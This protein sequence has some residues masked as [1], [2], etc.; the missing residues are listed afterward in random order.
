MHIRIRKTCMKS[1]KD[2]WGHK[3]EW[4]RVA[5]APAVVW[6]LGVVAMGLV[7]LVA[8]KPFYV[9]EVIGGKDIAV[10]QESFAIGFA[11][12]LYFIAGFVAY[13]T[14]GIN[15]LRYAVL[16]EGGTQWWTLHFD[17]R[18]VRYIIYTILIGALA[19]LAIL[20]AGSIVLGAHLLMDSMA[21]TLILAVL[22]GLCVLYPL[23][24]TGLTLAL[25]VFD[26]DAPIRTSWRLLKGNVL[27]FIGVMLLIGI[28]WFVI[29]LVGIIILALLGVLFSLI[30]LAPLA[31]IL[32]AP[33]G[34]VLW[35]LYWA[36]MIK[37]VGLVYKTLTEGNLA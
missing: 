2:V 3:L 29:F 20:V 17:R 28:A 30:D 10:I 15:G 7:Y 4:V 5:F 37:A 12:L 24:R 35:F 13:I 32:A 27:R 36:V 22:L 34:V 8:G 23:T 9:H 14:L 33:F 16:R 21:L 19:L 25:V 1:F 18:F 31:I 6:C 26:K 11:H